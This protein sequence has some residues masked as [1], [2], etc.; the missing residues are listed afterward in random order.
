MHQLHDTCSY[1]HMNHIY[2]YMYTG[3][4]YTLGTYSADGSEIWRAPVESECQ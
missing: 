1:M 4:Q 3:K 2:I